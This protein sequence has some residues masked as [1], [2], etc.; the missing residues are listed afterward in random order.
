MAQWAVFTQVAADFVA[1]GV[2]VCFCT[3]TVKNDFQLSN[4]VSMV[5]IEV[6]G[7]VN[8]NHNPKTYLQII[9]CSLSEKTELTG[10]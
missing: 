4:F 9:R 1:S 3:Q 10:S 6:L 8:C 7:N 5:R 2:R